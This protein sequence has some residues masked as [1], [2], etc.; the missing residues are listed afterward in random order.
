MRQWEQ[1]RDT[2]DADE[3]TLVD[4][5]I[6]VGDRVGFSFIWRG[7]GRGPEADLELS[8]VATM[9]KGRIFYQEFFWDYAEALETLGLSE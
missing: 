8:W 9:R 4:H 3:L 7:A 2:W 1:Q 6:D 5:S